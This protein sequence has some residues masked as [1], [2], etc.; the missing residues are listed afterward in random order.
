[1]EVMT[2]DVNLAALSLKW[3][4]KCL[5]KHDPDNGKLK[6]GENLGLNSG[7]NAVGTKSALGITNAWWN[8][9][10][11][12]NITSHK[13]QSGKVCGHYTQMAWAK[14]KRLGC[15]AYKCSNIVV[16]GKTWSTGYIT[17][18]KYSPPGNYKGVRPYQVGPSCAFCPTKCVG[19]CKGKLC[20]QNFT[21]CA[22]S[23]GGGKISLNGV[24]YSC[25]AGKAAGFCTSGWQKTYIRKYCARTCGVCTGYTAITGKK[26][27]DAT[28][29]ATSKPVTTKGPKPT[30]KY[31]TT[32]PYTTMKPLTTV[33]PAKKGCCFQT[34]MISGGFV[35]YS[36][37]K[38]SILALCNVKRLLGGSTLWSEMTC[39]ALRL[40]HAQQGGQGE[41]SGGAGGEEEG[42]I[43][44]CH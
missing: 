30:M 5:W 25:T 40:K 37:Y 18:C 16:N 17:V 38:D 8:E 43:G 33:K 34:Q 42:A 9:N 20:A 27:L 4:K 36:N 24:K 31:T 23:L 12:Y 11:W 22:D 15:A 14:S 1:M 41:E 19:G 6:T 44:G 3:A 26:A 21:R 35:K 28:C 32:R 13:C 7:W 39:T 10:R 2:W 29:K